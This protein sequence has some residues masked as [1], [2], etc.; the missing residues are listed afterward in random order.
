MKTSIWRLVFSNGVRNKTIYLKISGI[1][2]LARD[3][4]FFDMKYCYKMERIS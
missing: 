2:P 1:M 3:L 4:K